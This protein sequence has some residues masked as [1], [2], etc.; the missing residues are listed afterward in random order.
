MYEII[1]EVKWLEKVIDDYKHDIRPDYS[2]LPVLSNS[3]SSAYGRFV[4]EHN[5]AGEDRLLIALAISPYISN[6]VLNL[7]VSENNRSCLAQYAKTGLLMPTGETFLQLVAGN[8]PEIRIES[9]RIF[10]T[11]HVFYKKGVI[12]LGSVDEGVPGTQGVIKIAAAYRELFLHN[13]I[14]RPRYS[15][16]FPAHLLET[17]LEWS[18]LVLNEG[19]E[20][21]I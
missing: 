16:D 18:D 19:T 20:K 2:L 3:V 1:E 15:S 4:V 11:S 6:S 21:R 7:L 8:N 13:K 17:R 5:L 14:L 12:D 9:S 10:D